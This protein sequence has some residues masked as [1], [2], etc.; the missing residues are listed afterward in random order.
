M[1]NLYPFFIS[2]ILVFLSELGDKT[3]IL[4]LSFS[5][6]SKTF[7]I[8]LGVALGTFFSHGL[9]ILFGSKI[10]NLNNQSFLLI[11]KVI[12]Y[13]TFLLFGI[14]G[15]LS[16]NS[17]SE[18]NN[19]S[20]KSG[21]LNKILSCSLNYIF[22]VALSIIVGEIGDKTFLASLGLGLQ[23]PNFKLSLILG[24]ILGMVSSDSIAI[25]FGKFLG[26][27]IPDDVI[28]ILSNIIF[29][30]FGLIGLIMFGIKYI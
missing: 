25:F 15:F 1:E 2:F 17:N 29:I 21:L 23:Y 30:L 6:K 24:A 10:G 18:S 3:Q 16:K 12:T 11:L 26:S 20:G 22:I 7:N 8:L 4:V 19:K 28:D 27:K 5:N 14:F 9:A 13:I